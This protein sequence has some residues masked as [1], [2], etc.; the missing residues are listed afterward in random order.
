MNVD[1]KGPKRYDKVL[2]DE[3]GGGFMFLMFTCPSRKKIHPFL[4]KDKTQ[5][6][7]PNS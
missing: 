4:E 2:Y 3:M 1:K 7:G 5:K 6:S